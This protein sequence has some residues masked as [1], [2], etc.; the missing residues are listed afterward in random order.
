MQGTVLGV[1]P[2]PISRKKGKCEHFSDY[3]NSVGDA[4]A[5]FIVLIERAH[6]FTFHTSLDSEVTATHISYPKDSRASF[7]TEVSVRTLMFTAL[8]IACNPSTR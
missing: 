6:F 4:G 2:V 3:F 8:T 1:K 7:Q 5:F